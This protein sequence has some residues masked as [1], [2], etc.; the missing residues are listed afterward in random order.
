MRSSEIPKGNLEFFEIDNTKG[1]P[2]RNDEEKA[3]HSLIFFWMHIRANFAKI[4][5]NYLYYLQFF[6]I[7]IIE[8]PFENCGIF[9]RARV[10]VINFKT[11]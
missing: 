9:F 6:I 10:K 5:A 3:N 11:S 4:K 2:L 1:F 7:E 8:N